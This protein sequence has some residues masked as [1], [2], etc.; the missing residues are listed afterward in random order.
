VIKRVHASLVS[1]GYTVWIDIEKMQGSTVEVMASAVRGAR[2][3]ICSACQQTDSPSQSASQ[4]LWGGNG[5]SQAESAMAM[6][7]CGAG[8]GRGG[9]GVRRLAGL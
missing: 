4:Y 7:G 6:L 9:A 8:G 5:L 3:Y 1:R 2:P